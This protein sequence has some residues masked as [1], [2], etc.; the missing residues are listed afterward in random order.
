MVLRRRRPAIEAASAQPATSGS[1]QSNAAGGAGTRYHMAERLASIGDDFFIQTDGGQRVFK[2]DGK[3]IRVRDTLKFEDMRGKELCEI[4]GRV[5]RIRET[6]EVTGP[7][8]QTLATV[9]KKMI[10]PIRERFTIELADGPP[11]EVQGNVVSHEFHIDGPTGRVAE[12]SRRWFRV[13]DSY[14]IEIAPGQDDVVIL[15]AV[16]GIDQMIN[17]VG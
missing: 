6:I 12:V 7:E 13:R 17:D 3:A 10:S 5:A 2:V 1:A 14:G 9:R 15:A 11:L 16:V 4:Q 8:G